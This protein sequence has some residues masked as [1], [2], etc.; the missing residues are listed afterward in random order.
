MDARF[1]NQSSEEYLC[2]LRAVA[3]AGCSSERGLKKEAGAG[4]RLEAEEE[5]GDACLESL[6]RKR[7]EA[8]EVSGTK[9]CELP[10]QQAV[11]RTL[12]ENFIALSI[13]KNER[14]R[15]EASVE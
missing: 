10:R 12:R 11:K 4:A 14:Y 5:E 13:E 3:V 15:S 1:W 9:A 7:E 6:R 2:L 8:E